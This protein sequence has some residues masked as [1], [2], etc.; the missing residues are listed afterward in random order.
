MART[1]RD[2]YVGALESGAARTDRD[3]YVGGGSQVRESTDVR[4]LTGAPEFGTGGNGLGRGTD[5]PGRG[6]DG[7]G[8]GAGGPGKGT[9]GGELAS[10][11]TSGRIEVKAVMP[12]D[13]SSC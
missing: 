11:V 2:A 7:P 1:D 8:R 6:T 9:D 4:T 13:T 5:G 12:V 3:A 10:G